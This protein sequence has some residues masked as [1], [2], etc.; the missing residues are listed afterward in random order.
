LQDALE[1]L[2]DER[3]KV[4]S[5]KREREQLKEEL[6]EGDAGNVGKLKGDLERLER[7]LLTSRAATD[8]TKQEL[9]Q[10]EREYLEQIA[11]LRL[12]NRELYERLKKAGLLDGIGEDLK[13]RMEKQLERSRTIRILE[14]GVEG[15][16]E[17][18]PPVP[19][20]TMLGLTSHR[21]RL[22]NGILDDREEA[23]QLLSR[24]QPVRSRLPLFF[25]LQR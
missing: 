14:G 11:A 8:G 16:F 17:E 10:K 13:E 25:V 12:D 20:Q 3:A 18:L 5:L 23:E 9:A 1:D 24:G 4:A 2:E 21:R 7:A 15:D 19:G 22:E 6:A